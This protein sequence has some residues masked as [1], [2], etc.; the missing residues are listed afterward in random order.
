MSL[1][2]KVSTIN[3]PTLQGIQGLDDK[4]DFPI[5]SYQFSLEIGD[6]LVALFQS[7]SGMSIKRDVETIRVGGLNNYEVELPGQLSYGHVTLKSGLTSTDFFWK[8]MV[9]GQYEG[10][11][12][13]KNKV[14]LKHRRSTDQGIEQEYLTWDFINAFPVGWSI[15]D[16]SVND[17]NSIVVETLEISFD[18]FTPS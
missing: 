10:Y 16:L 4:K 11:A 9:E 5:P 14:T 8:W 2:Q 3:T 12:N 18:Y 1:I 7:L 13:S 6:K 15:S 17:S